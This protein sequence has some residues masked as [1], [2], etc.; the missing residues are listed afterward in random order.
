MPTT[1]SIDPNRDA[2]EATTKHLL[3][4]SKERGGMTFCYSWA[5]TFF[6]TGPYV[7]GERDGATILIFT[8]EV[9]TRAWK[10]EGEVERRS[11][12]GNS[13]RLVCSMRGKL[14]SSEWT[15]NFQ[16]IQGRCGFSAMMAGFL[17]GM[18]AVLVVQSHPQIHFAGQQQN[19]GRSRRG[20]V[21]VEGEGS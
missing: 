9:D 3:S 5:S 2:Y 1:T 21:R 18:M 19:E 13:G 17:E 16:R 20:L 6:S 15:R 10:L 7:C 11:D 4:N 14:V 12:T 8:S